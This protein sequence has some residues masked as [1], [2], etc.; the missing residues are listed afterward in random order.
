VLVRDFSRRP[1]LEG[2][3]RVTVGTA[4]ENDSFLTALAAVMTETAQ[5]PRS[6]P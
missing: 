6:E 4:P 5:T 2:C 3:V 1:R